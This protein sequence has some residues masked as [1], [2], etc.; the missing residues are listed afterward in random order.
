MD[1]NG[2]KSGMDGAKISLGELCRRVGISYTGLHRSIRGK[3]IRLNAF[4]R[5]CF[6]LELDPDGYFELPHL[7]APDPEEM[8]LEDGIILVEELIIQAKIDIQKNKN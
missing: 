6:G 7:I 5:I 1:C 3:T 8:S 2:L 4:E